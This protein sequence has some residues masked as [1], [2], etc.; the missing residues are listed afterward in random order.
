MEPHA[1]HEPASPE[2]D[3]G[4][5]PVDP[6]EAPPT[7]FWLFLVGILGA[8]A[9]ILIVLLAVTVRRESAPAEAPPAAAAAPERK[10]TVD[11]E[12]T[13]PPTWRGARKATWANDGSKT[14][15]FEL[16]AAGDVPVWNSW[17]RPMLVVRCLY[18]K[19]DAFVVL[20]TSTSYEDDA[21]RR[22]VRIQW[23]GDAESVQKWGVS[24]SGRELFAPDGV[25]LVRRM[26]QADRLQFQFTP[27][28]ARPVTADF[29][30]RGFDDLADHV[31]K[32]C[33]WRIEERI[34]RRN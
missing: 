4:K 6:A 30:V 16:A 17:A 3:T 21:D 31:A 27:F 1:S 18:G 29:A 2:I 5:A 20:G 10:P 15:A 25:A 32:T 26:T 19:T 7:R 28:N 9:G 11:V 22:T 12:S 24:E 8:L 33:G 23:D 13:P 34:A 14:I